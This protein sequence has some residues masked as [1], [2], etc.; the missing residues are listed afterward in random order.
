MGKCTG[1][2]ED[3]KNIKILLLF[4]LVGTNVYLKAETFSLSLEDA[5]NRALAQSL[6]LQKSTIDLEM[7]RYRADR[8][9]SELFP[10]F[11]LRAGFTILPDTPLISQPG[12]QY[13]QD[14][15][16]YSLSLGLTLQ[17]N[18]GIPYSMKLTELAYQRGLLDYENARRRVELDI[19][20]LFYNLL[21]GRE[22]ISNLE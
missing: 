11:S 8:L 13:N 15:L 7:A 19:S 6:N 17:F 18:G 4:F 20:K 5:K 10:S 3:W 12:F 21:A 9:W 2:R 16:S 22:N 14:G 1:T